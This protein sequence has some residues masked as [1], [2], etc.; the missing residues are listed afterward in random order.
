MRPH[1][2]RW[3]VRLGILLLAGCASPAQAMDAATT[4][5]WQTGMLAPDKLEHV[6]LAFTAG[7]AI[8]VWSRAPLAAAGGA[9]AC[10]LAKELHDRRRTRFD[11]G[12]LAADGL[13]AVLAGFATRSLRR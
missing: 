7:L 11:P 12:D 8:G 2:Q 3:N 6:S 4:R 9:V 13:G 5:A 1:S 10:G